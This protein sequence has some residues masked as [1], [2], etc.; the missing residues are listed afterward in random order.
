MV[1][2]KLPGTLRANIR[3]K[4]YFVKMDVAAAFD[5]IKQAKLMEV[6]GELLEKVVVIASGFN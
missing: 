1:E 6:I 5:S 2:C 4:L 3:P